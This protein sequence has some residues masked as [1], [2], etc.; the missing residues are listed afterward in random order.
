MQVE[1][2][3]G[4]LDFWRELGPLHP[5]IVASRWLWNPRFASCNQQDA[6]EV[7]STLL[8]RL[9][10]VG[11]RRVQ[12]LHIAVRPHSTPCWFIFGGS[13]TVNIHC[14]AYGNNIHREDAFN[15]L[16]FELQKPAHLST[17][18]EPM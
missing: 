7:W 16:E 3:S 10:A 1:C 13:Q 9:D 6:S 5:R 4:R 12:A 11:V 17:L 15:G 14:N 8:E 2:G 18:E